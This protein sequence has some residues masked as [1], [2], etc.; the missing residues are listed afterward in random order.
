ML[1]DY[2]HLSQLEIGGGKRISRHLF[3][4]R[5]L[6]ADAPDYFSRNENQGN[7]ILLLNHQGKL[8]A[9]NSCGSLKQGQFRS[10]IDIHFPELKDVDK[11]P[12]LVFPDLVICFDCGKAEFTV[13][14]EELNLLAQGQS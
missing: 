5:C 4:T 13:P 10:E 11:R 6:S 8:M 9:C 7:Q 2:H 14:K 3:G 1:R 12:I